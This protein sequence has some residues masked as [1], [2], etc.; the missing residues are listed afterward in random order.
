MMSKF[1]N[2]VT[3]NLVKRSCLMGHTKD[4]LSYFR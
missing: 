3:E 4:M 2:V 1:N